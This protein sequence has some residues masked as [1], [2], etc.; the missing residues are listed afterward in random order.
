MEEDIG[1]G[2]QSKMKEEV[3]EEDVEEEIKVDKGRDVQRKMEEEVAEEEA[4]REDKERGSSGR[5]G[6][7]GWMRKR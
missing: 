4:K 6:R 1:R 2:R 3:T 7:A 5:E